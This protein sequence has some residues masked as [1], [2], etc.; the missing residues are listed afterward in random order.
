VDV[1]LIIIKRY[2]Y[3]YHH[4]CPEGLGL[5]LFSGTSEL[6][7]GIEHRNSSCDQILAQKLRKIP[8]GEGQG[9]DPIPAFP[10]HG[11]KI[12]AALLEDT[13]SLAYIQI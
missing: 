1:Q 3:Y 9:Q 4:D 2:E 13:W 11:S 6:G 5:G 7:P 12:P 10:G 8:F